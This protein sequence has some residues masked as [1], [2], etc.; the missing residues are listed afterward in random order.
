MDSGFWTKSF[1]VFLS[2]VTYV[3]PKKNK[4][5]LKLHSFPDQFFAKYSANGSMGSSQMPG[6][7]QNIER[8]S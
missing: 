5:C 6:I 3:E 7:H 2:L 1:M 4:Q 8:F